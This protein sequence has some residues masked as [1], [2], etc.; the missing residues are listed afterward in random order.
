MGQARPGPMTWGPGFANRGVKGGPGLSGPGPFRPGPMRAGP[1][2]RAGPNSQL[3]IAISL[4]CI[5]FRIYECYFEWVVLLNERFNWS[6]DLIWKLLLIC[7]VVTATA[8]VQGLY[9]LIYLILLHYTVQCDDHL[10]KGCGFM[11]TCVFLD[12]L[13]LRN[14]FPNMIMW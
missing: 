1:L 10:W 9:W 6:G 4:G 5:S 12:G 7:G 8:I 3:Y 11:E 13:Y 2:G 14:N